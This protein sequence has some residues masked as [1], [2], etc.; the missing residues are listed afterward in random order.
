MASNSL[1]LLFLFLPITLALYYV[2]IKSDWV[3]NYRAV[4][5]IIM[6][7]VFYTW[8]ATKWM[9]LLLLSILLN[10]A[11]IQL[12]LQIALNNR[13]KGHGLSG[14]SK[15]LFVVFVLA[16]VVLLAYFKYF[17]NVLPLGISFFVFKILSA[18]FD[19][20]KSL[21]E[22]AA[23]RTD[24]ISEECSIGA[25]NFDNAN[26][27]ADK[28]YNKKEF[29]Q[30][31]NFNLRNY[32][33]YI[34][35]FPEL[36]SGPISRYK[37]F[38]PQIAEAKP[39]LDRLESG[40]RRF[41]PALFVKVLIADSIG[42]LRSYL[43]TG[44][45]SGLGAAEAWLISIF[46]TIYIYLDFA[47][48]S[49]MA[50]GLGDSLGYD[51][52]EN[53]N[54]PYSAKTI[55]DFWRRWHM[56]LS[57]WFRDYVYIPLG[58]NRKGL[59][60]QLLNISIVWALTGIWH[61]NYF[62]FFLWGL[63]YGGILIAEKMYLLKATEKWPKLIKHALT[64]IIVNF[65]W[66]LFAFPKTEELFSILKSMFGANSW[67]NGAAL[68]TVTAN[69]FLILVAIFCS[70]SLFIKFKDAWN[71]SKFVNSNIGIVLEFIIVVFLFIVTVAFILDQSFASFL[72]FQ[73]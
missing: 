64:L 45:S 9:P 70:S 61:G 28:L 40:L 23:F 67:T 39:S 20:R 55:T 18:W 13:E 43:L 51:V 59:A 32:S 8:G 15:L 46:Y 12:W 26:S 38:T 27:V 36:I 60:R 21:L 6:S 72:Y 29:L 1:I 69:L 53:F 49:A 56:S 11:F 30:T 71:K 48:Y 68:Y 62:N 52:P 42:A 24:I 41:L 47:S 34:S 16:N 73:F 25:D 54:S 31:I 4:L 37:N 63:F 66:V 14:F 57:Y 44:M 22:S 35:F 50:I 2:D 7:F 5:L 10:Y 17:S 3:K 33:L 65:G 58:G 19:I